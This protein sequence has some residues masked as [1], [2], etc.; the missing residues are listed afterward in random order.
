MIKT[1]VY[2]LLKA[3]FF[4][5]DDG[6]RYLFSRFGLSVTHYYALFHL[7][8]TPG[9]TLGALSKKLLCDKSNMTR[10]AKVLEKEGLI[11]RCPNP[12]DGRSIILFLTEEG[13]KLQQTVES[14]HK[15][16]NELRFQDMEDLEAF[17]K[18]LA[19]LKPLLLDAVDKIE[20]SL[21]GYA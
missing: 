1:K 17:E 19:K 13:E 7:K 9:S 4:T 8:N 10:V 11:Y 5:L 12:N 3:I 18:T 20:V 6:D 14:E 15:K 21:N 16:F 2:G